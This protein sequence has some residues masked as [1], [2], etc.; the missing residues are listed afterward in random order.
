MVGRLSF[1]NETWGRQQLGRKERNVEAGVEEKRMHMHYLMRN[2]IKGKQAR[3]ETEEKK[4][5]N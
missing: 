4:Q 1:R 5:G 3:K 2:G